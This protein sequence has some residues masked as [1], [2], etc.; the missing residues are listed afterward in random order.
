MR[1]TPT[2]FR[3][4]FAGRAHPRVCG[5][6]KGVAVL[7]K[8]MKGSSPRV[9]GKLIGC[10]GVRV[11]DGL[12]PACAGKTVN[13]PHCI[14]EEPAHPRAC[15]E[16]RE[17]EF[18]GWYE[19]G[20][21]PRMRGKPVDDFQLDRAGGLIPAHAGKTNVLVLQLSNRGAHPRACGEN[22]HEIEDA[23]REMGSSP[24]MRG[25]RFDAHSSAGI[26]GAH[27]R[28]C[29]ENMSSRP[30]IGSCGGSSPRMQG[31]QPQQ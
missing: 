10:A 8:G 20:S 31:K 29:G 1:K 25:K 7:G 16:N 13:I 2:K 5:E 9:R 15:G 30:Y 3:F 21:S 18:F 6:N 27:P 19:Q 17:I 22:D 24:R 23:I 14:C 4:G 28:A 12:I 26:G 11:D